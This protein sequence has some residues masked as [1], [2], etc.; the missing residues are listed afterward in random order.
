MFSFSETD[1]RLLKVF[2]TV[3]DSG[4]FAAA[5]SELNIGTSTISSHMA[6]LEQRLGAKLC[7]RGRV[8]FQLT[9]KPVDPK[10]IIVNKENKFVRFL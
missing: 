1:L 2:R 9:D 10:M 3:V 5:Q 6:T 8:G 7:Q 4:G